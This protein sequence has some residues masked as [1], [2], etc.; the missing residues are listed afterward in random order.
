MTQAER[1]KKENHELFLALMEILSK[2]PNMTVQRKFE[3]LRVVQFVIMSEL[4]KG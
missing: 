1:E 4:I 2:Y 3:S